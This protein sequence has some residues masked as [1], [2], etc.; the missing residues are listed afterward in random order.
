MPPS[1]ASFH[2]SSQI[3]SPPQTKACIVERDSLFSPTCV[4]LIVRKVEQGLQ[5]VSNDTQR[6]SGAPL[7][8]SMN[9]THEQTLVSDSKTARWVSDPLFFLPVSPADDWLKTLFRKR[10]KR[11]VFYSLFPFLS[12]H[13]PLVQVQE[14]HSG[15]R[16]SGMSPYFKEVEQPASGRGWESCCSRSDAELNWIPAITSSGTKSLVLWTKSTPIRSTCAKKQS[17]IQ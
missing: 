12:S 4:L 9:L 3:L 13:S 10:M 16:W 2:N 7:L 1:T 6:P 5:C 17:Q 14:T 8:Q 11:Y 15:P